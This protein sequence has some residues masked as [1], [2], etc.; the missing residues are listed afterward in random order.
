MML[1]Q[2]V[3][4]ADV[5]I[6]RFF[7]QGIAAARLSFERVLVRDGDSILLNVQDVLF[8]KVH[9]PFLHHRRIHANL[10]SEEVR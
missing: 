4:G 6:D 3:Q 2:L 10:K 5:F 8:L 7:G 1:R 9:Q